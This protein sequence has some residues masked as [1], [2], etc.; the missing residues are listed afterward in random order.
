MFADD[1]L[2]IG[3]SKKEQMDS[4]M[5]ILRTFRD[6]S[7]QEVNKEKTCIMF[8]KNV[9]RGMRTKLIQTSRYR[10][11]QNMGKYLGVSLNGRSLNRTDYQYLVEQI[12]NKLSNWKANN[13][14]FAVRVTL[15]KNVL[16]V[17]NIYPMMI[18][19]LPRDPTY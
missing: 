5:N 17:V 18:N 8:S 1:L 16:E 3:E 11:T 19:L 14:S 12:A 13:L 6:M 10:E 4:L 15:I 9:Q 7:G 2:L